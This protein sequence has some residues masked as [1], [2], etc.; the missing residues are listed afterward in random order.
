M[1]TPESEAGKA[2]RDRI[3]AAIDAKR[4]A[5]TANCVICGFDEWS[6]GVYHLLP[7]SLDPQKRPDL[8]GGSLAPYVAIVCGN[9]GN[10]HLL[11]LLLLGFTPEQLKELAY[12]PPSS[13]S[14][15]G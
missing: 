13:P 6:F 9:C 8:F 7:S 2:I 14:E 12:D 11:N 10:T 15:E 4:K 3:L 5:P 1:P